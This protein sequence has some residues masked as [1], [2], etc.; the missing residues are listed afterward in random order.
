MKYLLMIGSTFLFA[1]CASGG[2]TPTSGATEG[3]T[4]AVSAVISN[5]AYTPAQV[6]VNLG[7]RV[8]L[9]VQNNDSVSH[10]ISLPTFGVREFVGPGQTQVV[11]FVADKAGTPE[12]FCS[13]EHGEALIINVQG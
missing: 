2:G 6:D 3:Q 4:V 5:Y 7:D 12:T 11:E 13:G 8:I 1:S 9:T 10:G